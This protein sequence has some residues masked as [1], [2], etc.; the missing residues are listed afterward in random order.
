MAERA[1][2]KDHEATETTQD[3]IRREG[4]DTRQNTQ[5]NSSSAIEEANA[6]SLEGAQPT[7]PIGKKPRWTVMVYIAADAV[8][9]NFG[10]ESLK[11]LNEGASSPECRED[12]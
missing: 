11:Q 2:S 3:I 12:P 6:K 9:A 7:Q 4:T 5:S 8:L 1:T 10:V